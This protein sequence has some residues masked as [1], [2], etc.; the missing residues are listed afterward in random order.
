MIT[1]ELTE[2][3][4]EST[5]RAR[6]NDLYHDRLQ[7]GFRRTDR[8]FAWLFVVQ[9]AAAVV[10]ALVWSP[11]A[12]AGRSSS[13]HLHVYLA[14][15][16]G[17]ALTLPVLYL[18]RR[19]SGAVLTRHAIAFGQMTWSAIFIHLSGGRIE[20]H[21]H[22]FGSLAFLAFYRDWTLLVTATLAVIGDHLVRGMLWS[23]SIYATPNPEWWRFLEHGFWVAFEDVVLFMGIV[24]SRRE[25]SAAATATAALAASHDFVEKKVVERTRSLEKSREQYRMLVETTKTVPFE[26]DT[27]DLRLR[28][29]G[30]QLQSLL[31]VDGEA[32]LAPG[33][34]AERIHPDDLQR[35]VDAFGSIGH[36][37]VELEV[38][39]RPTSGRYR[40]LRL[41]ASAPDGS[42]VRGV[43]LD[44]THTHEL[45]L[46]LRQAQKLESIGRLASGVAH[47]INTP[48][49]YVNDS[50]HFVRTAFADIGRLFGAYGSLKAVV[51]AVAPESPSV[52]AIEL[53]EEETDAAYV[54]EMAPQALDRAVDGLDRIAA[55]VRSMKEFAHLD[56][57]EMRGVDI[58]HALE[59][60]L[61]IARSEYKLV[62][63]VALELGD[64]PP[65][66]CLAGE[67]NQVFLNL[68]VNA[69]H[70]IADA[71]EGT[72]R[73]G[74]ITVQTRAD[75]DAVVIA[76]GDTGG[77]IPAAIREQIFDPFFTTKE[78]GR[79]SGQGLAIARSVVVDQHG[80][81]LTFETELSKGTTFY[82][83]LPVAPRAELRAA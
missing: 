80:G 73:R 17:A 30:P 53:T 68:I 59:S 43:M 40:W 11:L 79:G 71:V 83:R 44:V 9:W 20:T 14:L 29:V 25:L 2:R 15:G 8:V 6:A 51:R 22:V 13:I 10:V 78:V 47:E 26:I 82:V 56:G 63:D 4:V 72:G 64:L 1:S 48:V 54:M 49:Q 35:L 34:L 28:Y 58:N 12:W 46:Q 69:A 81:T 67:V 70:A 45:E 42:N 16:V 77:G 66:R 21:F 60:T 61:N 76:I 74:L 65:V 19:R 57:R 27:L 31:G 5:V 39:L 7:A 37:G 62:A 55:I 50:V 3:P 18:V 24:Q 52:D 36:D 32:C 75:G 23:E 33:F 41:I 38:R